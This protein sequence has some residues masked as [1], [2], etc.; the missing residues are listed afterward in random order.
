MNQIS[1][2]AGPVPNTLVAPIWTPRDDAFDGANRRRLLGWAIDHILLA[3]LMSAVI[4]ALSV[5]GLFTFGLTW[6]LLGLFFALPGP[7]LVVAYFTWFLGQPGGATPGLRAADLQL[8]T[9]DGRAVGHLQAALRTILYLVTWA[10]PPLFVVPLFT[11][12]KRALHDI[13][14]GTTLIRAGRG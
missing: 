12:R 8:R 7:V 14:S 4:L 6:V 5:L 9:W 3:V 13:L 2:P 10:F 1:G 11:D